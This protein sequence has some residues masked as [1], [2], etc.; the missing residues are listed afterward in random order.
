MKIKYC[1]GNV[2]SV[3]FSLW[4][5]YGYNPLLFLSH[6]C[7]HRAHLLFWS[8]CPPL[9]YKHRNIHCRNCTPHHC[10]ISHCTFH[11]L[12]H[13]NWIWMSCKHCNIYLF[14][15][16]QKNEKEILVWHGRS[17]QSCCAFPLTHLP[18][19]PQLESAIGIGIPSPITY[20]IPNNYGSFL[21][22]NHSK[23]ICPAF[24]NLLIKAKT[25][26]RII[27]ALGSQT[28][29]SGL[30]QSGVCTNVQTQ[31]FHTEKYSTYTFITVLL[32]KKKIFRYFFLF[33]INESNTLALKMV[34]GLFFFFSTNFLTYRQASNQTDSVQDC[35]SFINF[36]SYTDAKLFSHC[37]FSFQRNMEE[38]GKGYRKERIQ[39][40]RNM[41]F[42]T[43]F[44]SNKEF[45]TTKNIYRFPT[46]KKYM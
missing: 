5:T 1:L 28:S 26:P 46:D 13:C 34:P 42:L 33:K 16:L 22:S 38:K 23:H 29:E 11:L 15:L 30:W 41:F 39:K 37:R 6:Q 17:K 4:G 18:H 24:R 35:E 14:I 40:R 36:Y 12:P 44:T 25:I 19:I 7:I 10:T 21:I 43:C 45:T 31:I 20:P 27:I 32:Q 9:C 8:Y 3:S 2:S